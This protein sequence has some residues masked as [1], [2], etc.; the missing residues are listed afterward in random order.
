MMNCTC[1]RGLISIRVLF[2]AVFTQLQTE[3]VPKK[4]T[5]C[6]VQNRMNIYR[7][8]ILSFMRVFAII[9]GILMNLLSKIIQFLL[10]SLLY[11]LMPSLYM[12][13]WL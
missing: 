6:T 8:L 3:I 4:T 10:F 2:G 9:Q 11:D 5:Y 1:I 13:F 12:F 7:N